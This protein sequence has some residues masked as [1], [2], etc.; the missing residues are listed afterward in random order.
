MDWLE[1]AMAIPGM[2]YEDD[3]QWLHDRA[4]RYHRI[5]EVGCWQGRS[6]CAMAT[7]TPGRVWTI[8][9]F[10]GSPS[11]RTTTHAEAATLDLHGLSQEHLAGLPVTIL[12]RTSVR[13]SRLFPAVDMVFID[14]DH[15][16]GAVL[17]DLVAWGGKVTG[18]LCGHDRNFPGVEQ[19]LALYGLPYEHGPGS[20]WYAEML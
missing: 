1:R 9:T 11:E 3:L 8:D 14:G 2:V 6:A 5:V 7:A 18:L 15:E 16:S 20:I 17:M 12:R 10:E 19:A 4:A 13:A